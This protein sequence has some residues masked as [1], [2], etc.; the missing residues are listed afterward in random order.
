V[1]LAGREGTSSSCDAAAAFP[2]LEHLRCQGFDASP[3]SGDMWWRAAGR[4]VYLRS[5]WLLSAGPDVRSGCGG[6]AGPGDV[7]GGDL[8]EG[9]VQILQDL[10]FRCGAHHGALSYRQLRTS[11]GGAGRRAWTS[12]VRNHSSRRQ[13]PGLPSD[14]RRAES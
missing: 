13:H 3:E 14:R 2:T 8:G 6:D 1:Q 4:R 5:V 9:V 12:D 11:P 10:T 7:V